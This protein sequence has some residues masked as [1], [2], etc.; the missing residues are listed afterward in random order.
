MINAVFYYAVIASK[1][2]Q[3]KRQ[4]RGRLLRY[5][6]NDNLTATVPYRIIYQLRNLSY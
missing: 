1:A 6:R 5:T 4:G 3:S 2:R